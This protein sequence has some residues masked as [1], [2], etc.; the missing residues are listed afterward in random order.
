MRGSNRER[1]RERE[2]DREVIF[3]KGII[4]S[5]NALVYNVIS[6]IWAKKQLGEK[7]HF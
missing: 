3:F 4:N 1:E 5:L 2:R 6:L 7:S